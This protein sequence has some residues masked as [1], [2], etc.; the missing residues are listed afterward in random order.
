MKQILLSKT[1]IFIIGTLM[2]LSIVIKLFY[3]DLLSDKAIAYIT[4]LQ[5]LLIGIFILIE[6]L[7]RTR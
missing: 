3:R 7:K 6:I 1:S 5:A 4:G 2:I